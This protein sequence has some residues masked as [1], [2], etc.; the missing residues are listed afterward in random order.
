MEQYTSY[1]FLIEMQGRQNSMAEKDRAISIL[2]TWNA[3]W[4][5]DRVGTAF[6]IETEAC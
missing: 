2:K 6:S 3:V 4:L 5:D 1:P